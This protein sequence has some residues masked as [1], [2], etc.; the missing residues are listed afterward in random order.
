[1]V[2][3]VYRVLCA[4]VARYNSGKNSRGSTE[5]TAAGRGGCESMHGFMAD[6]PGTGASA[7]REDY[8][9]RAEVPYHRGYISGSH[10]YCD[11]GEQS[12]IG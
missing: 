2:A 5:R 6:S 12:S 11:G 10:V 3:H 7:A 1:M 4:A 8:G 9:L